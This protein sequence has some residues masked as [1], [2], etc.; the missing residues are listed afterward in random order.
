[1]ADYHRPHREVLFHEQEERRQRHAGDR[2]REDD[3]ERDD[4]VEGL[5]PEEAVA[6]EREGHARAEQEREGRRE[7]GDADGKPRGVLGRLVVRELVEPARRE[8]GERPRVDVGLVE[9]VQDDQREGQVEED[10]HERARP[11]EDPS[12]CP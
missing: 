3:R 11:A 10:E 8:A 6:R 7:Q 1:M 12:L 5:A 4:E 9:R 2:A